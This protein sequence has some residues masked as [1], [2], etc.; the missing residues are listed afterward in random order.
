M[1][2]I[3]YHSNCVDG[4]MACYLFSLVNPGYEMM[5]ISADLG[6]KNFDPENKDVV[7]LDVMPPDMERYKTAKSLLVIDHHQGNIDRFKEQ[8]TV[9]ASNSVNMYLTTSK[10]ATKIVY[11]L[12]MSEIEKLLPGIGGI[13]DIVDIQDRHIFDENTVNIA[14]GLNITIKECEEKSFPDK[15]KN[16][17]DKILSNNLTFE[18]IEG[19]GKKY[20]DEIFTAAEK[21]ISAKRVVQATYEGI[22]GVYF[23]AA[24]QFESE[25]RSI[26]ITY[27]MEKFKKENPLV[28]FGVGIE[29]HKKDRT[30]VGVV[31]S[32]K[33]YNILESMKDLG[34]GGHPTA[35]GFKL[36][37]GYTALNEKFKQISK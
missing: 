1:K 8:K 13:V 6:P 21:I 11:D 5:E 4:G 37:G 12:Y 17:C 33:D 14:R 35:A 7:F 29:F 24:G 25:N 3:F 30:I 31:R 32:E 10:C 19:R 28:K 2:Y 9:L 22:L 20:L 18:Q 15:C 16:I 23:S 27:I 36:S 34:V 26:I